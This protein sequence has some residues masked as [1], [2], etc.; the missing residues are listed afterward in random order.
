MEIKDLGQLVATKAVAELQE[1][2]REF[3]AFVNACLNMYLNH[4]WGDL[5]DGDKKMNDDAVKSGEDRLL[6]S[7]PFPP[8]APW[9]ALNGWGLEESGIWIITDWDRSI[10]QFFPDVTMILF[11]GVTTI[12]FPGEY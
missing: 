8:G 1:S 10:R 2:S 9:E 12:L 11:P 5:S 3:N 6:A 7:Y 4:N